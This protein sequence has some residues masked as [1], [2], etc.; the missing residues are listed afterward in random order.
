[1]IRFILGMQLLFFC[2]VGMVC[3]LAMSRYIDYRVEDAASSAIVAV[4]INLSPAALS[5][6]RI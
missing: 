4:L 5:E 3:G 1:M 6:V 2:C